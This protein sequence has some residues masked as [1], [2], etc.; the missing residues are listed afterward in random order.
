M[1]TYQSIC[2]IMD[3]S[4]ITTALVESINAPPGQRPPELGPLARLMYP[5]RGITLLEQSDGGLLAIVSKWGYQY[6]HRGPKPKNPPPADCEGI[7]Q[8]L[9]D[10]ISG[11]K[12]VA[13]EDHGPQV[14]I[15]MMEEKA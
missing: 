6:K 4:K 3:K 8:I 7:R 5:P 12:I 11:V 15:Y 13:V 10:H 2:N 14:W 9:A 1:M